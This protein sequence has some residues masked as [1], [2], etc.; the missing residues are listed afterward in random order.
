MINFGE[1]VQRS[2][3][4][5][6]WKPIQAL[7][8]LNTQYDDDGTRYTIYGY[9]GPEVILCTIWKGT[10][11]DGVIAGGYTQ[12]QNDSD[13][14]DFE[15]NFKNA[16]NGPVSLNKIGSGSIFGTN[17][18]VAA[19][20]LGTQTVVFQT[21][22][23]WNGT[24][25]IEASV[26]GDWFATQGVL[27][28]ASVIAGSF[29]P[30]NQ[31][32]LVNCGGFSQV[33]LRASGW[34]SGT[35]SVFWGAGEGLNT[36]WAYNNDSRALNVQAVGYVND[37]APAVGNAVRVSGQDGQGIIRTFQTDT[38]GR[39][40]AVGPAA[41]G[42]ALAGNPILFAGSDG[43]IVRNVR[44][45]TTGTLVTDPEVLS[46]YTVKTI[47]V[48][49]GNNKSM[50]A[51]FNSG[52]SG[53][54]LKLRQIGVKIV[55]GTALGPVVNFELHP[56]TG[57]SVLSASVTPVAFETSDPVHPAVT[58]SSGGTV[59]GEGSVYD[60]WYFT[61][62]DTT[63]QGMQQFTPV[64]QPWAPVKPVTMKPGEGVHLK[65]ATNTASG[66]WDII[67]YFTQE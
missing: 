18:S 67:F 37:G 63:Q 11:P 27:E 14:S 13:K 64:Y 48:M 1:F 54:I 16:G 43:G 30:G 61:S 6:S 49:T 31:V 7:K 22:G 33:R 44:V 5:L 28:P 38:S 4:W 3:Q 24:V 10:V 57:I 8:S 52:S 21:S 23:S 45:K 2:Y 19:N 62:V 15:V 51:L 35:G 34:T 32:V 58:G 60:E 65:C 17:M 26:G 66:V 36:V 55:S 39:S 20:V 47:G 53:K 9:D 46:S 56:I 50:L 25:V 41:T 42:S 29:G 59:L 40:L 12:V